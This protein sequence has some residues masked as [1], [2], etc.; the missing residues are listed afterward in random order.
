[1]GVK[2]KKI[3]TQG[4]LSTTT[5][6]AGN[7]IYENGALQFFSHPEGYV[8][9][10]GM[11]GYD[12]VYQYK[13]HLGNVRL[14]YTD[15]NG[16]GSIDPATEIIEENNY[17]P[18]GLEHNG[19][20]NVING[21]EYNYETFQGQEISKELGYNMLEFKY[22][23]YDPAIARFVTIDPLTEDYTDWGPYVF[24]GNRVIDARE[25]EGLEPYLITGRSFIPDESVKSPVRAFSNVKSFKGDNRN[26]YQVNSTD[27][28]TEQKV[29]VDFDNN[30]V[31]GVSNTASYT[32]GLD[33]NGNEVA[34]SEVGKA[35]PTPTYTPDTMSEGS[36][37]V[38]MEVDASN[39]LVTGAPAINYDVGITITQNEDGTFNFSI[40]GESDGF[41]A[42]EFFITNEANGESFLIHGSNPASRGDTPNALFP[43]MDQ[44]IN[45]SGNSSNLKPVEEKV[46]FNN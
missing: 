17:Y 13:D 21:T 34:R 39:K 33:S 40:Q 46:P 45:N 15:A 14:S 37:T 25:L 9:P 43:P 12:Y 41:P 38:N 1:M 6:Y 23:H 27:Y 31:T 2:L 28:R 18:F 10:D 19:Y 7:F 24:S 20:N 42:Y 26:S 3:V 30:K 11:G 29:R 22:R 4:G 32:V 36:T 5:E 44:N 16:D 8:T 35:G